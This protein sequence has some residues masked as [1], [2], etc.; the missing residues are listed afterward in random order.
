V[1]YGERHLRFY[2]FD[3]SCRV[4]LVEKCKDC[5]TH[6]QG[7]SLFSRDE[8]VGSSHYGDKWPSSFSADRSSVRIYCNAVMNVTISPQVLQLLGTGSADNICGSWRYRGDVLFGLNSLDARLLRAGVSSAA[9]PLRSHTR[10]N[11]LEAVSRRSSSLELW[12]HFPSPRALAV[13]RLGQGE[14]AL[15]AVVVKTFA[16]RRNIPSYQSEFRLPDYVGTF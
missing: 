11:C 4:R 1:T 3:T 2:H 10:C 15:D 8:T 16:V 5:C 9:T 7:V 12:Q 6:S 13:D 14:F